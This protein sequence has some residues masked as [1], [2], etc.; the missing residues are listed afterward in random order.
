MTGDVRERVG[1][2]YDYLGA[3]AQEVYAKPVREIGKLDGVTGPEDLLPHPSVRVGPAAGEAWLRVSKTDRPD[4]PVLSEA[5]A[6][7]VGRIKIDDPFRTPKLPFDLGKR[8]DDFGEEQAFRRDF[9][10]WV[11]GTWTPWAESARPAA[12]ARALYDNL[13]RLRQR[14]RTDEAT[15]ELVWGHG[16][17]GWRLDDQAICHPLLITRARVDFDDESG[18]LAVVPEGLPALELDCVQGLGIPN[19]GRLSELAEEI[20]DDPVDVW[21]SDDVR[22]VYGRVLAPLGLDARVD[23]GDGLPRTGPAPV[24]AMTWRLFV[25]KRRVMFLK[26]FDRLKESIEADGSLPAPMVA[27]AADEEGAERLPGAESQEWAKVAEQ[28]LMPLPANAEQEQIARK[29]AAHSGVTVQGPPGTGKSHTIANLVSHLVAHGKRVLVTAHKDQAL[30]VLR[31]KIPEELRDLSLAVLGS[32]SADITALQR[33]VNAI[34]AAADQV[35]ERREAALVASLRERLDAVELEAARLGKRLREALEHEGDQFDFGNVQRRAPETAEWLAEHEAGL[36]RIPDVVEPG[37]ACPLSVQELS[38]F[39]ALAQRTAPEDAAAGMLELPQAQNLPNGEYLRKGHEEMRRLRE[40]LARYAITDWTVV[41]QVG[42]QWLGDLSEAITQA[43]A[44]LRRLEA[45]WLVG[46]RAQV[47]QSPQW[48]D[49]WAGHRDRLHWEVRRCAA[50]RATSA[51][52]R[53]ELP[54]GSSDRELLTALT[55]LLDRYRDG[56]KAGSVV[57]RSLGHLVKS[58]RVDGEHPETPEDVEKVIAFIELRRVRTSLIHLWNAEL[59]DALGAPRVPPNLPAVEIWIDA[60]VQ[61]IADALSWEQEHW[62]ALRHQ[63]AALFPPEALPPHPTAPELNALAVTVDGLRSRLRLRDLINEAQRLSEYLAANQSRSR[64]SSLWADLARAL[65]GQDWSLWDGTLANA[66]RLHSLRPQ[67]MRLRELH[68]QL[69]TVTP[70]WAERILDSQG[71]TDACGD[72]GRLAELWQWRQAETWLRKLTEADDLAEVQCRLDQVQEQRRH[73]TLELTH[74]SAWLSVKRNLG[75]TQRQALVGWLQTLR[76]IGRGTGV[77][78]NKWRAEAQRLMPQAMGAVPVWIM[79]YYRVAESFDPAAAPPFDVV[80]IDESSQCDVFALGLLGLGHKVVVVGDDKQ[81]SPSSIGVRHDRVDE[82]IRAYLRDFPNPLL[83]DLE[84]SLYDASA[85]LFPGVVRLREHFRCLPQIIEFSSQRYYSGEIQP[86]REESTD[87]L[88]GPAV[89]AVHVPD[90]VRRD[91]T[92]GNINEA[93]AHALVDRLVEACADPAYD[94]RTMGVISLL[95]TSRQAQYIDRLLLDKLGP[96]EYE[97]RNLRCGD[98]YSFQGDER[99]V[100]FISVVA[101]DNRGAFTS[102]AYEQRVNVAA[103]RARD[104]LWVFHSI[105]PESL[106]DHD[107]RA[108]LIRY[109]RDGQRSEDLA[110]DL[111]SRCDSDFERKVLRM[112]LARDYLVTPQYPVGSLRIDLVVRGNGR[113]LAIECDGDKYHGPDQWEDDLRRQTVLERLGW[114]FWR[115]RGSVFYRDPERALSTLWPL[116][117][118]QGIHPAENPSPS[119]GFTFTPA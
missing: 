105:A 115:V 109:A 76:K 7:H 79:P 33:S 62:P 14:L 84:S 66:Q 45:A 47:V 89:Q 49:L 35:D 70:L 17:L 50:F 114:R 113:K 102:R 103:S 64:A 75:Q 5:I 87:R 42:A 78:A 19:L 97:R 6:P 88:P 31:D 67:F 106:N 27:L 10:D 8:F 40:L 90:G 39:F 16:L 51:G 1:R 69:A 92:I 101:D 4:P 99:D 65:A 15:H 95:S 37:V 59:A 46:L 52:A 28:L 36:A 22:A 12:A 21:S 86:L 96:E 56:K 119:T 61:E 118:E 98:S 112:L 116:L 91:T 63:L 18:D 48:R 25:R 34:A 41:D 110:A 60:R 107:Q 100:M 38:E 30:A 117:A 32:S 3:L 43:A 82:L 54:E 11:A 29:L 81:I 72:P 104:Q 94:G 57:R 58:V 93:E 13:F 73:L 24:I 71:A 85:R 26:F 44:F 53:I 74:R 83:L 2:L 77:S 20:E 111:E 55:Q 80:I 108:A 68:Y 23:E 9:A